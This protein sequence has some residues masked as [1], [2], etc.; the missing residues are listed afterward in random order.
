MSEDATVLDQ[1]RSADTANFV[2]SFLFMRR[3]IGI[4]GVALPLMLPLLYGVISGQWHLLNSMSRYY[5]TD[6]RNLFVGSLCAIGVFL[7]CYRYKPSDFW[8][9]NIAGLAAITVAL[10][11]TTPMCPNNPTVPYCANPAKPTSA[12]NLAGDVHFT[13]A[14]VLFVLLAYFCIF[15]F[16]HAHEIHRKRIYRTCGSLILLS[17][18]MV[19]VTEQTSWLNGTF[20]AGK[21]SLFWY[22]AIAIM[23]FGIAWLIEGLRTTGNTPSPV[24]GTTP[25]AVPPATVPPPNLTPA[26]V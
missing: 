6:T 17:I 11:P 13:A 2:A 20:F 25:A 26:Q 18:L 23:S 5:Y 22:E 19:L 8:V 7:F 15:R 21:N 14:A 4:L 16:G 3:G 1:D 10:S 24:S 9:S 12:A